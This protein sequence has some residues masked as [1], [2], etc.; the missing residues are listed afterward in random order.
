V[1]EYLVDNWVWVIVAFYFYRKADP[2][3]YTLGTSIGK[4]INSIRKTKL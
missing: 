2:Y 3:A 4:A 1:I